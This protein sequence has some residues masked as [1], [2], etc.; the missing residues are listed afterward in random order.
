MEGEGCSQRRSWRW[1]RPGGYCSMSRWHGLA[2]AFSNEA[3]ESC[4]AAQE[5][6]P[7][8]IAGHRLGPRTQQRMRAPRGGR[9]Q[10]EQAA[11]LGR[12][13]P[14]GAAS[15]GSGGRCRGAEG[16]RAAEEPPPFRHWR[17]A[18]AK[19]PAGRQGPDPQPGQ[20]AG[21][22]GAQRGGE[23]RSGA[24]LPGRPRRL[25]PGGESGESPGHGQVGS[26]PRGRGCRGMRL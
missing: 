2:G 5:R 20:A 8:H 16:R 21:R 23:E 18:T 3:P 7:P 9:A 22:S 4:G 19:K 11:G 17:A 14:W 24:R 26:R 10:G 12:R 1:S 6:S 15:R 25:S 13:E